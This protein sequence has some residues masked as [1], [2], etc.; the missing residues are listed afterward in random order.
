MSSSRLMALAAAFL[1]VAQ[2]TITGQM[3]TGSSARSIQTEVERANGQISQLIAR[4]LDHFRK[5]KLLLDDDKVE[6]ARNEFDQAVDTLIESGLDLRANAQ[7]QTFFIE[8]AE[9]IYR[10]EVPADRRLQ[11]KKREDSLEG[12]R[13]NKIRLEKLVPSYEGDIGKAKAILEKSTYKNQAQNERLVEGAQE[14]LDRLRMEIVRETS[15]I[16]YRIIEQEVN[17]KL[18]REQRDRSNQ[19]GQHRQKTAGFKEQKFVPAPR[20][21]LLKLVLTS[22]EKPHGRREIQ[23][24][25]NVLTQAQEKSIL[26]DPPRQLANRA[27]PI[28]LTWLQEN[29]NDPYSMRIVRWAISKEVVG[30]GPYWVVRVRLRAK[31]GFGAYMLSDYAFYIRHNRILFRP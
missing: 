22:E 16:S 1:F 31:N 29:L 28:V 15:R 8:L 6:G 17:E 27:V 30:S 19:E 7:L 3:P 2:T 9:R 18:D 4:A 24:R 5:G 25:P 23:D 14:R 13:N 10:E 21:E 11:A 12:L 20:D 26:G